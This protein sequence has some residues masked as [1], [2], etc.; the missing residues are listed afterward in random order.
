MSKEKKI[1]EAIRI[2]E[3]GKIGYI[4]L[5]DISKNYA[6]IRTRIIKYD[7]EE[8]TQAYVLGLFQSSKD[9]IKLNTNYKEDIE[10]CRA[11]YIITSYIVIYNSDYYFRSSLNEAND[12]ISALVLLNSPR[13]KT[14]TNK[15]KNES[16]II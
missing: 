15:S 8:K 2:I 11:R 6:L 4:N 1:A 12:L 7:E 13:K 5:D 9:Y 10:D 3:K 16:N 14:E